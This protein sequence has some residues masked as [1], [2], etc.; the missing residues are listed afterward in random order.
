MLGST[1][2]TPYVTDAKPTPYQPPSLYGN[3]IG[4][5]GVQALERGLAKNST[6]VEF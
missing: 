3:N 1:P 6:V 5:R 2:S 4:P